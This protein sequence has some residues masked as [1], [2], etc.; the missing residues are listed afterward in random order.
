MGPR[1]G[2]LAVGF[3]LMAI[4]RVSGLV[5]PYST[6]FLIDTVIAKHHAERLR[7]LVILVLCA[8]AIQG[9]TSF[10][11]TQL[12][13]KAAQRLIAEL[14]QKI[15]AHVGRRQVAYY[16]S[17]KTGVLV[18][19]IMTDVEGGRNLTGTGLV[20]FAGGL[21]TA[22]IAMG[23]LVAY[24]SLLGSVAAPVIGIVSIGTQI[25]EA[26]A[27]LDRMREVLSENPEDQD[28]Q[29]TLALPDA[30]ATLRF[31]HVNFAYEKDKPVLKDV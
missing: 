12:L 27:G 5:L 7:P 20:E 3:L 1:R 2:L 16:A 28:P 31:D 25:T 26:I 9:V 8:T 14:R 4:N 10:A 6:K 29:R 24:D 18:S 30:P 19:R 22:T 15:Q 17:H 23:S 13:S 21:I 11:L